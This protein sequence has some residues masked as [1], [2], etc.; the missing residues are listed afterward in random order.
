MG[1]NIENDES[2]RK[3]VW[4][5]GSIAHYLCTFDPDEFWRQ[6]RNSAEDSGF[7]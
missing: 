2:E 4:L 5:E 6:E 1:D 7:L 3:N